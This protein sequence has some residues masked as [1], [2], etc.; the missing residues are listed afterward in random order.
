MQSEIVLHN[1]WLARRQ[2]KLAFFGL[3]IG[4]LCLF[5]SYFLNALFVVWG[6]RFLESSTISIVSTIGGSVFS[7]SA[8]FVAVLGLRLLKSL[9]GLN[10]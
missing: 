3:A 9:D 7:L 6:V 10:T 5:L 1:L 4:S 8:L 2:W